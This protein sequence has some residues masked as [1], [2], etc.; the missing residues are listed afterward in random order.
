MPFERAVERGGERLVHRRDVADAREV[1]GVHRGVAR[2][3]PRLA[4]DEARGRGLGERL[5]EAG[6]RAPG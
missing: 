6:T 4:L 1:A 5:G 3:V 2:L